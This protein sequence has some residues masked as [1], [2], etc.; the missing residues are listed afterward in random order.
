LRL[1]ESGEGEKIDSTGGLLGIWDEDPYL[2]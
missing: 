2:G 1:E